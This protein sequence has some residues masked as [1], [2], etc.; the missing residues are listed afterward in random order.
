MH[1]VSSLNPSA[2]ALLREAQYSSNTFKPF[3]NPVIEAGN[4]GRYRVLVKRDTMHSFTR[5]IE[6]ESTMREHELRIL[7]NIREFERTFEQRYGRKMNNEELR[8]LHVAR[9]IINQKLAAEDLRQ[10]AA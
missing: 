2:E 5:C 3:T 9:E 8:L 10:E 6:P 1:L 4:W 7:E